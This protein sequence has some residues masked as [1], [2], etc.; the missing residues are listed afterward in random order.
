MLSLEALFAIALAIGCDPAPIERSRHA[1]T[2]AVDDS[3]DLGVVALVEQGRVFCSGTLVAPRVVVTAAHCLG[4]ATRPSVFF[5]TSLTLGG[6]ARETV[7][8]RPHPD[9]DP[10]SLAN[11]IAVLMLADPAPASAS[12]WPLLD[13][14]F[15]SG[16]VGQELRL[17]GFGRGLAPTAS[18]GTKRQGASHISDYDPST[19]GFGPDPSQTCVGDSGGPAFLTIDG[20]EYLA[21]VTS[22][23]DAAC[24]VSA[25]DTR[26][27]RV[28]SDF[29][30]PYIAHSTEGSAGVGQ[31]CFYDGNCAVGVCVVAPDDE[32]IR[33]CSIACTRD[34]ECPTGMDCEETLQSEGLCRFLG[35][36]PGATG[37][38]CDHASDCDGLLCLDTFKVC[39]RAC[40]PETLSCPVTYECRETTSA[41]GAGYACLPMPA[42]VVSGCEIARGEPASGGGIVIL[43]AAFGLFARTK[44]VTP[45]TPEVTSAPH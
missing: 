44:K 10:N 25:R 39:S 38:R 13:Q 5:G 19:F 28:V 37:S 43:L 20:I 21:G 26:V 17:V 40:L 22:S 14:P 15:E 32:Q 30:R 1:I 31:R 41:G 24:S 45:V 16:F 2:N 23:G 8:A 29:I 9:Y 3:S 7:D 6:D 33:Y 12:S 42:T 27:D 35:P 4:V 34:A 36:T 18:V 11:D